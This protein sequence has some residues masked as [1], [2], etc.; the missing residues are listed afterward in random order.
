[1]CGIASAYVARNAVRYVYNLL[2]ELQHRGQESAGIAVATEGGE[3]KSV[4]APGYV[5]QLLNRLAIDGVFSDY[6]IGHVR[7]STTGS[8]IYGEGSQPVVVKE[9]R[10]RF[11]LA[12]N[13]NIINYVDISRDLLKKSYRSDTSVLVELIKALYRDYRDL[14]E[15]VKQLPYIV[16]G[17][18]S[19]ALLS[20]E[21]RIV[22]AKDTYGFK[23]LAYS[24]DGN[25]FIAASESSA[26]DSIGIDLWRELYPGEIVSFDGSSI[27]ITKARSLSRHAPC[28]FEYIYFSRP[29]T[30]FNNVE[31]HRARIRMGE[32]LGGSDDIDADII[33]PVPDSG[34]SAAIGYSRA[35]GIPID[36]GLM[37]NR[38]IGRGFIMPPSQRDQ[39]IDLKY[40]PIRTSI[41][42]K[43]IVLVDDSLIRGTTIRRLIRILRRKGAREI[44]VRIA[45]PPIRYPCFM[46][47][48]FPTRRELIAG[49]GRSIKDVE[50]IIGADSLK[51]LDVEDLHLATGLCSLC[52]A[53]FT[54]RYPI[55]DLNI[56][57]L[58]KVFYRR[59]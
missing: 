11:A 25:S 12:F 10:T 54:G 6:A 44:H 38:Y 45:S 57:R 2:I 16:R 29:D 43:N 4:V 24:Y 47:I 5:H 18:Y 52:M 13:G 50:R 59:V 56:D 8:Y 55:K 9:G 26:L 49:G 19:L 48:D 7:Y 46:G 17:S 28:S 23:P 30:V 58:E 27:E 40:N 33:V 31:V 15:A 51:Y 42:G 39:I 32:L 35:T 3:V 1:M 37:R 20:N 36:E 14:V 34:R 53:C 21:P 22:L 41:S